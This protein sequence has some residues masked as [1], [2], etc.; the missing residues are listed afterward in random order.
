MAKVG[1]QL[2][3]PAAKSSLKRVSVLFL[4]NVRRDFAEKMALARNLQYI[5]LWIDAFRNREVLRTFQSTVNT[6]YL[7]FQRE[8]FTSNQMHLQKTATWLLPGGVIVSARWGSI[9]IAHA[10]C[11]SLPVL[12]LPANYWLRRSSGQLLYRYY[13]VR[14]TNDSFWT[15]SCT[16]EN[17]EQFGTGR[18]TELPWF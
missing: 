12:K 9:H 8:Y 15:E 1:L 13:H 6:Y 10:L 18:S 11:S 4:G 2:L 7:K 17:M 14:R 16:G 5:E 3:K